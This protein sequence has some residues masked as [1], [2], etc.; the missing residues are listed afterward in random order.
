MGTNVIINNTYAGLLYDNEVF[1]RL[2][3]GDKTTG[4]IH[5]LRE[6]GKIDVRLQPAGFENIDAFEQQLLDVINKHDGTLPIG[7]KSPPEKI[8]AIAAMSKKNF[9]KAAGGLYRKK[10][11]TIS[12]QALELVK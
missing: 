3:L 7:D 2:H 11:I 5:K 4:F 12:P 10:L 8:Y 6:D 1:K 9:K